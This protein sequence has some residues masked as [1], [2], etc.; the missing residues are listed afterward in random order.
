MSKNLSD[1]HAVQAFESVWGLIE[2]LLALWDALF[3]GGRTESIHES[4]P[5]S[6]AGIEKKM[7][8]RDHVDQE[9][10]RQACEQIHHMADE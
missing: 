8:T 9:F 3:Q 6:G 1:N 10:V 5:L 2:S 4:C 7:F